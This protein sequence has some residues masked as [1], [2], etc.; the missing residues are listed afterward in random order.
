MAFIALILTIIKILL[1]FIIYTINRINQREIMLLSSEG[2]S[3]LYLQKSENGNTCS[4][5]LFKHRMSTGICPRQKCWGFN[6][7]INTNDVAIVN[8]SLLYSLKKIVDL[9][10]EFSVA[11]L[12]LNEIIFR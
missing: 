10:P 7:N 12:A 5:I 4:N 2:E 8:S 1:D 9:F 3:C 6:I 11:I